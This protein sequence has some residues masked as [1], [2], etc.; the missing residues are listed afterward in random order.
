M[1]DTILSDYL[2]EADLA[3]DLGISKRT[4][5]RWRDLGTG[6]AFCKIGSKVYYRADAVR[7]WLLDRERRA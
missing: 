4:A 2:T 3:A 1:P 5:K 6:P 7:Q